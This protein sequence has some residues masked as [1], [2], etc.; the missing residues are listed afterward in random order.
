MGSQQHM[1][2]VIQ[3]NKSFLTG[4][5]PG[6][7]RSTTSN[8]YMDDRAQYLIS[9]ARGEP[10]PTDKPVFEPLTQRPEFTESALCA[11][12]RK[13]RDDMLA[14]WE[15]GSRV[16]TL[17]H[18]DNIFLLEDSAADGCRMCAQFVHSE[19][20]TELKRAKKAM[21]DLPVVSVSC[22]FNVH[23]IG[24]DR[25]LDMQ[26]TWS[27][28]SVDLFQIL[29]LRANIVPADVSGE[30]VQY[31]RYVDQIGLYSHRPNTHVRTSRIS[32]W[33]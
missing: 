30:C 14:G 26:W 29:A 2:S 28:P 20:E 10:G 25:V 18:W 4:D 22:R 11:Y 8:Q 12:Y 3:K 1:T 33:N 17:P 5:E 16:M 32:R 31:L 19:S 21:R 13:V 27:I 24:D 23:R 6:S 7:L 15:T 9:T